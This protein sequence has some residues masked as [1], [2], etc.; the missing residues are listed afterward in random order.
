[1]VICDYK[2][3]LTACSNIRVLENSDKEA[4]EAV[5]TDTVIPLPKGLVQ[6]VIERKLIL[7]H[8]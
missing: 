1:M 8:C 3:Q 4:L 2:V 6:S 5:L 7:K